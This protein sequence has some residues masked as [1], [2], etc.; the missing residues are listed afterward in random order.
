MKT[1]TIPDA[2]PPPGSA[3]PNS[4]RVGNFY[5]DDGLANGYDNGYAV[6]GFKNYVPNLNYLTDVGSYA[7][8]PSYYGTFDQ[9]GN[10]IEWN[11]TKIISLHSTR[12]ARGGSWVNNDNGADELAA[13]F[14]ADGPPTTTVADAGFRVA[15]SPAALGDFNGDGRVDA[16]DYVVW[17]KGL[18]TTYNQSDYDV[19]RAHFG[20]TVAGFGT[21]VVTPGTVPESSG[22]RLIA[23]AILILYSGTS[24]GCDRAARGIL[25]RF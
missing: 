5:A 10:V 23:L 19:W 25:S 13:S 18:G 4:T 12:G 1:N 6:S 16:A 8:A 14:S 11:E 7:S 22:L 21:D 9:G 20:Q 15:S 24:R 3:A 2:A 17:R